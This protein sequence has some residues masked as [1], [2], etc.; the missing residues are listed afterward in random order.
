M[1][2]TDTTQDFAGGNGFSQTIT[3]V[4][5]KLVEYVMKVR[6]IHCI[7]SVKGEAVRNTVTRAG[8]RH[9]SFSFRN[10]KGHSFSN[11][12]SDFLS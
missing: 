12:G 9:P 6:L 7:K 3:T 11:M 1:W 5:R 8:R 10:T 4:L 2:P